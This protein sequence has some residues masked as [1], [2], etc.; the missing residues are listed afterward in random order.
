MQKKLNTQ[1]VIKKT[2]DAIKDYSKYIK[3]NEKLASEDIKITGTPDS[4]RYI[5]EY[6]SEQGFF[7]VQVNGSK[8]EVTVKATF[9]NNKYTAVAKDN[10]V[11]IKGVAPLHSE[12]WSKFNRIF[13]DSDEWDF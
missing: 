8:N 12:H 3:E 9:G 4:D 5:A 7:K 10:Q 1:E 11:D 13:D 6:K 2:K